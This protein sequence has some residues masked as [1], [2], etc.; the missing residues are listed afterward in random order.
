M[1]LLLPLDSSVH[2]SEL[3][4][5]ALDLAPRIFQL[6]AIHLRRGGSQPPGGAVHNRRRHLQ[7]AQ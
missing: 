2:A 4:F 5:H 6:A 1:R 3:A 7:I